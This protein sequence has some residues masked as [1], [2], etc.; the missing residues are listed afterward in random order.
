VQH[1]MSTQI[2]ALGSKLDKLDA[3]P[4]FDFHQSVRTV[5]SLAALFGMVVTGIIWVSTNQFA[6]FI[7]EQKGVNAN[8]SARAEK[9]EALMERIAERVGWTARV[10]T[11]GGR[12]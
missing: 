3:R 9:H 1:Q 10:E 4:S 7:A 2:G 6:V 11:A 5:L 12:R 8:V